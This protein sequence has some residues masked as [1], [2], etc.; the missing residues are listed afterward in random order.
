MAGFALVCALF[1]GLAIM[2]HW[3]PL[4]DWVNMESLASLAQTV[5]GTPYSALAVWGAYVVAG[6]LVI[7]VMAM[8]AVTGIVFG[9]LVGGLYAL[10]GTVLSAA[11]TYAIGRAIGRNAVSRVAGGRLDRISQRIGRHGLL[12]IVAI[13]VIPVAPFSIVN[14]VAGASHISF[15]HFM[16]GTILGM[17][18]GIAATVVFADRLSATLKHPTIESFIVLGLIV[19]AAVALAAFLKRRLTARLRKEENPG[20]S[21]AQRASAR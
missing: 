12:A 17:A 19:A 15:R 21:R 3:T 10:G 13:R 9:P 1:A 16:L 14:M 18:P 7:P 6:V 2:W 8:I 5:Q 11:A 4:G 20:G